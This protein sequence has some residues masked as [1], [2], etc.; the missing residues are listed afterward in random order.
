MGKGFFMNS[1]IGGAKPKPRVALLGKFS[2]EDLSKYESMFPTKWRAKYVNELIGIVDPR[3]IDLIIIAPDIQDADP[4]TLNSH[5]ICFSRAVRFLPGPSED[6]N[7]AISGTATTEEYLL[8]N[9]VLSVARL[10]ESEFSNLT[11]IRGWIRLRANT[12]LV[13]SRA[14]FRQYSVI[15]ERITEDPLAIIYQRESNGLSVAWLPFSPIN[16]TAWVEVLVGEWAK[17][18]KERFPFHGDWSATPQ[19]MVK[20]EIS[21]LAKI[22]ALDKERLETSNRIN[23]E[24]SELLLTLEKA[25]VNAN[26]GRRRL[27]T[28]QGTPLVKEVTS[29]LM[30]IGFKVEVVDNSIDDNAPKREDLRLTDPIDVDS[31]WEAIV[32]VRGYLKGGGSTADLQR[33]NRFANLY[34]KEK[35]RFPDK[36]IYIVNGQIELPPAY[37]QVPL[38]PAEEDVQIFAESNG[39]VICTLDLFSRLNTNET[40]NY[41][42]ILESIKTMTGRWH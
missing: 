15:S 14:A 28:A 30:E 23:S 38:A 16:Q 40:V 10:R 7:I 21:I 18:D 35:G 31:T 19:W 32:E 4:F 22:A 36:C 42:E 12:A 37:R 39:L 20:E 6:Y 33:L 29:A 25:K 8:P 27:I 1:K 26:N 11:S 13:E 17:V 24:I 34:S 9:A 3:D 2:K 41:R 5:I